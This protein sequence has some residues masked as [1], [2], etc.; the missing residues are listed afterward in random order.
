MTLGAVATWLFAR[1][2]AVDVML[3]VL[4]MEG[5]WLLWRGRRDVLPALMPAVPI[6]L[7]L[8]VAL[9]GGGWPWVA[10]WLMLSLPV[11]LYDLR[12]RLISGSSD[13]R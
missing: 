10:G 1:G 6:L 3:A 4:A 12:R 5:G 9:T 11:H 8:R 7:A 13:K 2:H